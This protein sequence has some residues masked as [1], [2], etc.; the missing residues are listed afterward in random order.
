[1]ISEGSEK[2]TISCQ[3]HDFNEVVTEI[4]KAIEN[5]KIDTN[6]SISFET[7]KPLIYLF[8]K[9]FYPVCQR[10]GC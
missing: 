8:E 4:E 6:L 9:K 1:M 7:F 5:W 2:W 10:W 3:G